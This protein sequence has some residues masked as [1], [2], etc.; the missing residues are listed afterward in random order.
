[1]DFIF[2]LNFLN[3]LLSIEV[4]DKFDVLYNVDDNYGFRIRGFFKVLEIG[5]YW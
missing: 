2:N 1:M 4:L 5:L 3:N